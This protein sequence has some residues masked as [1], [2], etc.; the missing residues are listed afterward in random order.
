VPQTVKIMWSLVDQS[1]R[2][3]LAGLKHSNN[4]VRPPTLTINYVV[5]FQRICQREGT[6]RKPSWLHAA[7][8]TA[9][10]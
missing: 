4:N 2:R 10:A 9:K 1:R 5:K 3:G 6:G 7:Q 8:R